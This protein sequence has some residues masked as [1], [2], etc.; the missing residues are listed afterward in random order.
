LARNWGGLGSD[1]SVSFAHGL[2]LAALCHTRTREFLLEIAFA[3]REVFAYACEAYARI[4][5][6]AQGPADKRRL[7]AEYAEKWVP[8]C[9]GLD[10]TEL[11]DI[12]A[13]A[14][15]SR[16]GW[17]CILRQCSPVKRPCSPN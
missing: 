5:E 8:N 3:K 17:K 12:L 6:R 15:N 9:D 10:R 13:E 7:H 1:A 16:N 14:V 2:P 4:L 11:V